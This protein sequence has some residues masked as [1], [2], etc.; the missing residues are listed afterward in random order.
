[1]TATPPPTTIP[2]TG[3]RST[4]TPLHENV[5]PDALRNRSRRLG[6]ALREKLQ[7]PSSLVASQIQPLLDKNTRVLAIMNGMFDSDLVRLLK[8]DDDE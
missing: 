8:G 3:W 5:L 2:V 4:H 7:P 1:M 6:I